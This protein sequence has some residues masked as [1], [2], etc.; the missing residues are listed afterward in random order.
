MTEAWLNGPIA[1]VDPMLMPAAHAFLQVRHE[2]PRL[3][4]GLTPAQLWQRPGRSASIG[5][6]VVHLAGATER[7]LTYARGEQLSETQLQA[8]RAE[9][10]ASGLS[11]DALA[12]VVEAAMDRA[13][14]EL[15]AVAPG[16]VTAPREVG[17]QRLPSTVLGLL[18]HAAEHATRH[19]GQVA[20]LRQVLGVAG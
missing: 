2:V 13:I 14:D 3:L 7:L 19:A 20:T 10:E 11:S 4:A 1:G 15:R 5:F 17:R 18:F 9:R 16:D 12:A 6:H 8:A